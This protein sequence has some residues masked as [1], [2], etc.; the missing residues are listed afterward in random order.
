M[1]DNSQRDREARK[2]AKRL[3]YGNVIEDDAVSSDG[4]IDASAVSD[5]DDPEFVLPSDSDNSD[6]I[7]QP[8]S[9]QLSPVKKPESKK[10]G[11]SKQKGLSWEKYNKML[12]NRGEK[13]ESAKSKKVNAPKK[14][15]PP[16]KCKNKCFEKVGEDGVKCIFDAFWEIGDYNAQ[17]A[18]LASRMQINKPKRKYTK[19]EVSDAIRYEYTVKY[20]SDEFVLCRNAFYSIHGISAKRCLVQQKRMRSSPAGTPILDKRGKG[21]SANKITGDKLECV[22]E[23]IESLPTTTSHYTRARA[24]H[25]QYLESGGTVKDMYEKYVFWMQNVHPEVEVVK[26]RFYE[27]IFTECYNIVFKLPRTDTCG[28]CDKLSL[29]I[30]DAKAKGIDTSAMEDEY[31]RHNDEATNAQRLLSNSAKNKNPPRI[32]SGEVT[33]VVAMDLQQTQPCPRV[34]TGLAYYLRKL[35]IYNFCIYDVTKGKGSM[36]VWDEATGGRGSE[37]IASCLLKW[38]EKRQQQGEEFDVLRIY[39]DNCAGQNKN[40][41]VILAALRMIHAKMLF[42]VEFVYLISG[43]SYMPCDRS[44]GNIEKK[45]RRNPEFL[46]TTDDYVR[47]IRTAVTP[48]FE[49]FTLVKE[50]FFNFREL[51]NHITKR[52]T[53]VPFSKARQLVVSYDYK[54]GYLLKTSYNLTDDDTDTYRSRLMKGNQK[55]SPSLFDLSTVAVPPAYPVAIVLNLKKLENLKCL[56]DYVSLYAKEWLTNLI[57]AQDQLIQAGHRPRQQAGRNND[58]DNGNGNVEDGQETDTYDYEAPVRRSSRKKR[59][60]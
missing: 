53:D 42:R 25:R 48:N 36:F 34:S 49:T 8:L 45:F 33:H 59:K 54:E 47:S 15:G 16:C 21:P 24:P 27:K 4:D 39:C 37:E 32:M 30:E 19:K 41:Y 6:D 23:H 56:R 2:S 5:V 50:D 46:Q 31:K 52:K 10:V 12:K 14:I 13:Y 60:T 51:E 1:S 35:W 7:A 44:F 11:R 18:Y 22:Y 28:T 38:V 29:Q 43:H 17:N 20:N 26:Q 3:F 57:N 55:Y 40:I 9:P 58:D